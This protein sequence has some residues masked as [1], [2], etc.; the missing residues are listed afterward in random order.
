MKP[1]DKKYALNNSYF[2]N[3]KEGYPD[4]LL[5]IVKYHEQFHELPFEYSGENWIYDTMLERQK[6]SGVKYCQYLTP[7]KIAQ[8]IA[9]LTNNFIPKDNKVLNACCGVGQ[10]ARSLL[11]S[12]LDVRGFD[13]DPEMVEICKM[14]Y[15][16]GEFLQ[17]KIE[18]ESNDLIKED[19]LDRLDGLDLIVSNPPLQLNDLT[20]FLDWLSWALSFKGRAI[21]MLPKNTFSK[22]G[23]K[24]LGH[25]IERFKVLHQEPVEDG[26]GNMKIQCEL[27]IVELSDMYKY[28]F[29]ENEQNNKSNTE[30]SMETIKQDSIQMIPMNK[31]TVNPCNPRKKI[32]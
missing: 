23:S 25:L 30:N 7:D 16:N 19:Q 8:Q 10:I 11:Q 13:I 31:I 18:K 27:Y 2:K 20:I 14:L 4:T 22:T 6:R 15:P 17:Y 26:A 28:L 3:K 21:L 1:V 5:D 24:Q 29:S 9:E 32:D 12:G